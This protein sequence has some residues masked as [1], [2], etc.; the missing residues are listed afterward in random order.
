MTTSVT[1]S[2]TVSAQ[3]TIDYVIPTAAATPGQNG[4]N[5]R[6]DVW[7]TNHSDRTASLKL[8]YTA[9]SLQATPDGSVTVGPRQS[10]ALPDIVATT[11]HRPGTTGLIAI[12]LDDVSLVGKIQIT[13]ST[14]NLQQD[15]GT[16]GVTVPVYAVDRL[17]ETGSKSHI[18]LTD[19]PTGFRENFGHVAVIP[20]TM[21]YTLRDEHGI[22]R[23]STEVSVPAF[24]WG[25]MSVESLFGLSRQ[26]NDRIEGI[27][28]TG[29]KAFFYSTPVDQISN[30][31]IMKAAQVETTIKP[32]QYIFGSARV[33]GAFN[34]TWRQ[35]LTLTNL[36]HDLR[37][38]TLRFF[39]VDR[40][41]TDYGIE[42]DLTL[43]NE[44]SITIPDVIK[45]LFDLD[46]ANG[47]LRIEDY[48]GTVMV[49]A[50]TYNQTANGTYGVGF[51]GQ[52]P[53]TAAYTNY[54]QSIDLALNGLSQTA[55]TRT[56][57]NLSNYDSD[58]ANVTI[59]FFRADG[60]SLG[61]TSVV[62]PPRGNTQ[63]NGPLA[64]YGPIENVYAVAHVNLPSGKTEA[65]RVAFNGTIV[66]ATTSQGINVMG[67]PLTVIPKV[68]G[69][70]Y[71]SRW[72]DVLRE[73]YFYLSNTEVRCMINGNCGVRSYAPEM[74]AILAST[75]EVVNLG[76]TA[77]EMEG[78]LREW[79][80][81]T[82]VNNFWH[83]FDPVNTD[84][85]SGG[86]GVTFY[87]E[88][89]GGSNHFSMRSGLIT[90]WYATVRSFLVTYVELHPD[91]YGGS[92]ATG[93]GLFHNPTWST[94][95]PN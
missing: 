31:A 70:Q 3:P 29:D 13:S 95:D 17:L 38:V 46:T 87:Y 57:L 1:V 28:K 54:A 45:T 18:T 79:A 7:I 69:E 22:V 20:T 89:A 47:V 85:R 83:R 9:S 26:K 60:T 56:N 42:R 23:A 86:E 49:T 81:N 77:P 94:Q 43:I 21:L 25:Q 84:M 50:R 75:P 55:S 14:Y 63:I 65:A 33:A 40:D 35:D 92:A 91:Q 66:N 78:Y 32:V 48:D 80:G 53:D 39:P 44:S 62:L 71:V 52:T 61:T 6:T 24:G 67:F 58:S 73:Q 34:S 93:P 51:V 30:G 2:G 12:D 82:S 64:Q 19:S 5:W 90:Q 11:F 76:V 8:F 4:S 68:S 27:V 16:A 10:A 41:N 15:G 59:S 72:L 36:A 37:S 74:A 88:S